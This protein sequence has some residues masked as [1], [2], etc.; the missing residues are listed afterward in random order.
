MLKKKALLSVKDSD[1]IR[2][3]LLSAAVFDGTV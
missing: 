1:W 3:N 2:N